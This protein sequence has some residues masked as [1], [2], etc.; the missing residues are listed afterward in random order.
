MTRSPMNILSMPR[1]YAETLSV[2]G[3]CH[4]FMSVGMLARAS[5]IIENTIA[6]FPDRV[7]SHKT[8]PTNARAPHTISSFLMLQTDF[9]LIKEAKKITKLKRPTKKVTHASLPTPC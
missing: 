8:N 3:L 5:A 9:L 4:D 1:K 6:I 2:S 7:I